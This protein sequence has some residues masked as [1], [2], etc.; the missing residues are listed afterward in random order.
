[1]TI[2]NNDVLAAAQ[3]AIRTGTGANV[4]VGNGIDTG[5]AT[6]MYSADYLQWI[7]LAHQP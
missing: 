4:V 7:L 5:A 2:N 6:F 1:M 3:C